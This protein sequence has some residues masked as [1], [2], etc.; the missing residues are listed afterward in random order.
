MTL[1]YRLRQLKLQMEKLT[2]II[3]GEG[4]GKQTRDELRNHLD[5]I[6]ELETK[7][8][9]IEQEDTPLELPN[10]ELPDKKNE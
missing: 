9:L 3:A 10:I 8:E 7:I 5:Y 4:K 6:D 1:L 2:P